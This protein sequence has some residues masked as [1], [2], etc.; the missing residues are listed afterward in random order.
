MTRSQERIAPTL[1][2][3]DTIIDKENVLTISNLSCSG[4][5]IIEDKEGTI[6]LSVSRKPW[7]FHHR[8]IFYKEGKPLF[9]LQSK[10][11]NSSKI[12]VIL[13][14]KTIL[15][16]K[17]RMASNKPKAVLKFCNAA[18]KSRHN[19]SHDRLDTE[20]IVQSEDLENFCQKIMMGNSVMACINRIGK[21]QDVEER[22]VSSHGPRWEVKAEKDMGL[23][24]IAVVVVI[25]GQQ[26]PKV[27]RPRV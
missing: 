23:S 18:I 21:P 19:F 11:W 6:V 20:L 9:E 16:A 26:V 27:G 17:S 22:P 25:I 10:W 24:L 15:Q 8:R 4:G 12:E 13:S 1:V 3:G 7:S 5:Y 14:Q 2:E